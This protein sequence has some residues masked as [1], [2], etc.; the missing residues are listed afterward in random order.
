M[1][2]CVHSYSPYTLW[3]F[4]SSTSRTFVEKSTSQRV[5]GLSSH[6]PNETSWSMAVNF[7]ASATLPHIP[8]SRCPATTRRKLSTR[9]PTDSWNIVTFGNNW[10]SVGASSFSEASTQLF[11]WIPNDLSTQYMQSLL[12][13]LRDF[14]VQKCLWPHGSQQLWHKRGRSQRP[15]EMY[16]ERTKIIPR[17]RLSSRWWRYSV[18]VFFWNLVTRRLQ[19][20]SQHSIR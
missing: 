13:S 10:G 16:A 15:F 3:R 17:K 19:N 20:T 18:V 1:E 7:I 9:S 14:F 6:L 12:N 4:E 8:Q 11:A 5:C 2:D